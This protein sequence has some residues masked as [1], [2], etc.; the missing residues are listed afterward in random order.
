MQKSKRAVRSQVRA[1]QGH[2]T[3][4]GRKVLYK[5]NNSDRWSGPGVVI[6][7]DGQTFV[8]EHGFQ[9]V[10]VHPCHTSKKMTQEKQQPVS[11]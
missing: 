10:K 5:R 7:R 8:V 4:D 2:G 11:N 3:G 6:G 1:C 9:I